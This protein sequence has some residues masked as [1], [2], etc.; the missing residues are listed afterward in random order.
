M[1]NGTVE[2]GP[3]DP[4]DFER[5]HEIR[6]QA[7]GATNPFDPDVYGRVPAD[8]ALGAYVNGVLNAATVVHAYRQTWNGARIP[9]GG[10]GGVV[11][12]PE[13]RGRGLARRLLGAH[14][15]AMV[16]RGQPLAA[17]YPTTASLY[18]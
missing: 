13:A 7:F 8:L 1:T 16:D 15:A 6:R 4:E 5:W 14:M 9:C 3:I 11:V 17:L 2:L 12:A 18:R 10:V